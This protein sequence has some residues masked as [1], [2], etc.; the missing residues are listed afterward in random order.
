MTT[1]VR[2]ARRIKRLVVISLV[3][4]GFIWAMSVRTFP[5]HVLTAT[6]LGVGWW[7]MPMFL[8]LSLRRPTWRYGLLVPSTLVSLGLLADCVTALSDNEPSRLGWV[9]MTAGVLLGGTLGGWF[10]FRWI[11][12][13][14]TMTDPFAFG[15][16]TAIAAHAGLV[17]VGAVVVLAAAVAP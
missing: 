3:A 17:I 4:L 9:L 5:G 6:M 1:D 11:R 10:W 7:L 8:Y 16:W 14:A 2:F 12:V 13:P 15:R